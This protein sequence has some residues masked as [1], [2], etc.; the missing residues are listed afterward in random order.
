MKVLMKPI[1]MIAWF[2]REG[3]PRPI[4]FRILQ[5][6][7][8]QTIRVGRVLFQSEEKLA[9]NR[10]FLYRC[11]S[12]VSGHEKVYELKYELNTC[13]WYIYKL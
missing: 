9:G 12:V 6:D 3:K 1:E 4:K 7:G 13:K 10:M 2:T 5:P 11:Q 8:Y